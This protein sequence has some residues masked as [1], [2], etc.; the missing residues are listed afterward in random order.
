MDIEQ[1]ILMH[2]SYGKLSGTEKISHIFA[3]TWVS[4]ALHV[5]EIKYLLSSSKGLF[6]FLFNRLLVTGASWL[7]SCWHAISANMQLVT[8]SHLDQKL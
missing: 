1:T 8:K 7:K 4:Q 5:V 2:Q 3:C 6:N